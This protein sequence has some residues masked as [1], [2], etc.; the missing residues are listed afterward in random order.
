MQAQ[1]QSQA[2]SQAGFWC[3]CEYIHLGHQWCRQIDRNSTTTKMCRLLVVRVRRSSHTAKYDWQYFFCRHRHSTVYT[4]WMKGELR[5]CDGYAISNETHFWCSG[6]KPK[7]VHLFQFLWH[8][9]LC[10]TVIK[11][12]LL[13]PGSLSKFSCVLRFGL[14]L[15]FPTHIRRHSLFFSHMTNVK[16]F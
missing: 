13:P 15:L 10:V 1:A 3:N 4:G 14:R 5:S 11:P 8:C 16:R 2:Q 7:N 12:P 6:P 9:C